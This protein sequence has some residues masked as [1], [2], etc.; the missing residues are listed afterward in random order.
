MEAALLTL[1]IKG[2]LDLERERKQCPRTDLIPFDS[3]H[4][5][6]A[7]LHHDH[8]GRD[9]LYL[10]GAP[11]RVLVMC[12]WQGSEERRTPLELARWQRQV[13][14]LAAKGYRVLAVA[15]Q[16][17]AVR[18]GELRFEDVESGLVL[19]GLLLLFQMAFTYLPPMQR[20][21]GTA[22]IGPTAWLLILCV[23]ASVL[24]LVELEKLLVRRFRQSRRR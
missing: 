6:M 13:E 1:A 2:G 12:E 9:Y 10:K 3:A 23:G 8:Q 15:E 18:S 21:F 19:L 16:N 5:F 17:P 7:T 14:S 11:E 22:A 24:F 4:Q 20:L